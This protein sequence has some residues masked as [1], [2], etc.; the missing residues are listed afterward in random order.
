MCYNHHVHQPQN[1]N[2]YA[3]VNRV[4]SVCRKQIVYKYLC[5]ITILRLLLN[6]ERRW[7]YVLTVE[8]N[9]LFSC[10]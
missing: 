10:C 8:K 3:E 4:A 7:N 2:A 1:N 6:I 9:I 5:K